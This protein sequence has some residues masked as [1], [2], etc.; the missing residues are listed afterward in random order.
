MT[1]VEPRIEDRLDVLEKRADLALAHLVNV[2]TTMNQRFNDLE[3][4]MDARFDEVGARFDEVLDIL[5]E[6]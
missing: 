1:A 4:K 5:R 2:T 3:R 6:H